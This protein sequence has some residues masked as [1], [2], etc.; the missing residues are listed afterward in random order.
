[1]GNLDRPC[2]WLEADG[3]A[4]RIVRGEKSVAA[5]EQMKREPRGSGERRRDGEGTGLGLIIGNKGRLRHI[6]STGRIA[7]HMDSGLHLRLECRWIDRAPARLISQADLLRA[8][9]GHL[10][11][12]DIG[13]RGL[14][15]LTRSLDRSFPH[16][17]RRYPAGELGR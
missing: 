7:H 13:D 2:D 14:E 16:I 4:H 6:A 8:L 12:Y 15:R 17:D 1:M 9:A 10:R 3:V 11:G 5:I